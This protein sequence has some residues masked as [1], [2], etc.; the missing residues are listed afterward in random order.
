[1]ISTDYRAF[2]HET[3]TIDGVF[4]PVTASAL[5]LCGELAELGDD[6]DREFN[7]IAELGDVTWYVFA[8]AENLGVTDEMLNTYRNGYGHIDAHSAATRAAGVI[9]DAVKKSIWGRR[10]SNC[11]A[12]SYAGL[13]ATV[14]DCVDQLA[15]EHGFTL[16]QVLEENVRKLRKRFGK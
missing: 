1:M 13:L 3:G 16:D 7:P 5:G 10:P 8:L 15:S 12:L 9:A 4:H 2:V 14:L 11:N 6:L